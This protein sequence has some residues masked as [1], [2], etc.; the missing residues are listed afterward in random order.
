LTDI[1]RSF[2]A[3][4]LLCDVFFI[5]VSWLSEKTGLPWAAFGMSALPLGSRDTAPFGLGIQ[6]T[7]SAFGRLRNAFLNGLSQQ[8]LMRDVTVHLDRVR[9]SVGLP[10]KSQD[11]FTAALSPFLY[12]QG[13]TPT[14][15]YPR[16]DL[17]GQV[18]FIGPFL[19]SLEANFTQPGWWEELSD[20]K[21]V[22]FVTQGTVATDAGDLIKPAIQALAKDNVL[23]IVTTGGQPIDNLGLDS[24]PANVRVETFIPYEHLLPHVDVMVTNAGFNGVQLALANG[25]PLVT[26]G[27]TEEKPEICARVQ[28][29]GVGIDLKT[30]TPRPLQIRDAVMKILG[31]SQYRQR[32]FRFKT[33]IAQYDAPAL[34]TALLEQL[35]STK[36]PV[37]RAIE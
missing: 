28:W 7:N 26:A 2:P 11:F 1:L 6:P 4:V 13:T 15:E 24:M 22:V 36:K 32:A 17:P 10:P 34:A 31:S 37:L 21:P 30:S 20:G 5:G 12:L 8:V 35:A 16:S 29:A 14:F 19:P 25:V 27:Q 18:H 23:V 3:D 9:V 33:E